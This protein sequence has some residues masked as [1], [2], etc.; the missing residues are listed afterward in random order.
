MNLFVGFV[1]L[2]ILVRASGAFLRYLSYLVPDPFF[3]KGWARNQVG[4][5]R[6]V[7]YTTTL[8]LSTLRVLVSGLLDFLSH[9]IGSLS[10]QN[11]SSQP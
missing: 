6:Y 8:C 7:L 1:Y 4:M 5:N 2:Y 9:G 10:D 11:P 3:M